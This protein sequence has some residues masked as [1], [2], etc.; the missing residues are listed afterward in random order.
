MLKQN[1][2]EK[3]KRYIKKVIDENEK[4]WGKTLFLGE[5]DSFAL[6][7]LIEKDDEKVTTLPLERLVFQNGNISKSVTDP[8][9]YNAWTEGKLVFRGDLMT[10]VARRIERWYNVK[11]CLADQEIEKYSFRATFED[12]KLE[13]VL[14]FLS[15]TSPIR[16]QITPRKLLPD[17][18]YEK[19][20]VTIY[21]KK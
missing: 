3:I 2:L 12:D 13:D 21:L 8:A 14:R 19:E 20:K 1:D 9:K 5:G 17:G 10:E 18:T 11:I 6:L 4:A 15:L 7:H 16:Y